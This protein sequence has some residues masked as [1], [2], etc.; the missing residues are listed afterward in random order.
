V[1]RECKYGGN[2]PLPVI[3]QY[4]K[5]G[6]EVTLTQPHLLRRCPDID[7]HVVHTTFI[8]HSIS[9]LHVATVNYVLKCL[10]SSGK[11]IEEILREYL[12][13]I[14][15][16]FPMISR[17]R[18]YQ[19]LIHL[20]SNPRA[21]FALLLLSIYLVL[22]SPF[23]QHESSVTRSPLY[24]ETKQLF[25]LLQSA[26]FMS[27]EMVQSALLITVYEYGHGFFQ[28]AYLSVGIC[29]RMAHALGWHKKR[30][31]SDESSLE[32]ERRV[33]WGSRM[34]ER[35]S[36]LF[37]SLFIIIPAHSIFSSVTLKDFSK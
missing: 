7:Y 14:G 37:L 33:V 21:D 23:H 1:L 32:E 31:S 24:Y 6:Y 16:W 4:T 26:E 29:A 12:R 34:F 10:L 11:S 8:H 36:F 15:S 22:Q 5:Q 28:P 17:K 30:D 35:Y 18:L 13:T 3:P 2:P 27:I 9:E 19:N 25:G 20:S